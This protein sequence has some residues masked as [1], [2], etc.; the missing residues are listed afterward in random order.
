[1]SGC[2]VSKKKFVS[3]YI[4]SEDEWGSKTN[5]GGVTCAINTHIEVFRING[6][7]H[8]LAKTL[9]VLTIVKCKLEIT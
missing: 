2:P 3:I 8:I 5:I 6:L 7:A 9:Y 1:M 4:Y